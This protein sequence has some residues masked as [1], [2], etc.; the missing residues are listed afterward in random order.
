MHKVSLVNIPY[1]FGLIE[2][3]DNQLISQ[4]IIEYGEPHGQDILLPDSSE[5]NE[6][7]TRLTRLVQ[8]GA[9]NAELILKSQWALNLKQGE[10]VEPHSHHA[11]FHIY[12]ED[13]WSA[14]YYPV[15]DENSAK[16]IL[17]A[18]W[19]NT[20]NKNTHVQPQT[21]MYVAF[22]SYILHW[23]ER[24]QSAENRLSINAT[25]APEEPNMAPNVDFSIYDRRPP[26]D[27]A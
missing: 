19:C 26:I 3:V 13:Y 5:I 27:P 4:Q 10:S 16:L 6:L 24:Q 12:P 1:F 7:L 14:V 20:V 2:D 25:F 11:N 23:T 9:E 15:A 8:Y 18:T 21:G 17:S 22:P